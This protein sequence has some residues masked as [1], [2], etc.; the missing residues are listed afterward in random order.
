MKTELDWRGMMLKFMKCVGETG[1][2]WYPELW[3]SYG[4]SKDQAKKCV[5]EYE[6]EFSNH[7][8]K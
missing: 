1:G 3:E 5:S 6:R 7:E 8:E 4:I 2:D